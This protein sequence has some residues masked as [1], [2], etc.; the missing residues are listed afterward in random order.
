MVTGRTSHGFAVESRM[1][2]CRMVFDHALEA[3]GTATQVTHAVRFEGPL[4]PLFRLLIGRAISA[5]LPATLAGLKRHVEA[6]G[7]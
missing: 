2:A 5:G 1:P 7:A 4:A 3:A 6:G